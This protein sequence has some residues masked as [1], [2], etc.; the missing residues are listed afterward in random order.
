MKRVFMGLVSLIIMFVAIGAPTVQAQVEE[1]WPAGTPNTCRN[2]DDFFLNFEAGI[3]EIEIES[4][5]PSMQF[6]STGALNWKY[7]DIRT[8]KYNVYPY[9]AAVYETNGN[10][11]AWLGTLGD[12]GRI[13]F[14]GGGAT[15]STVLVSTGSGLILDAYDSNNTLI[16]SSG[17]ADP[18]TFTRTF[19]RLTVEAPVG[20][21][22]AYLLIHD[23]G[24][25]WLI[26][27]L[28]TDANKA[29]I[30][31]PGRDIGSHGDRFDL[32]FVP[33]EDYGSPADIDTWLPDFIQDI[34]D[35][36][37]QRLDAAAP[38]TGN[39]EHFNFYYTRMQG[40]AATNPH[41]LP[42]DLTQ[43]SPFADAY[44][45][46][47]TNTFGDWT[48]WG[49]PVTFGAEGAVGRSFIHE[50]GHGIFGLADEYDD[51]PDCR[52]ARFEPA[53]MPN[54]W[55]TEAGGRADAT[56]EGWNPDDIWQFTT[57][58]GGWWKLGTDSFIMTD[59][60]FFANGWGQPASRRI[61]WFLDQYPGVAAA[62]AGGP[63]PEAEKSIWL[64]IQVSAGVF[65]LLEESYIVDSPPDY[66]PGDDTFTV[67]VFSNGNG[68]L[69]EF[70]IHDP[71]IVQAERDYEGPT[72]RDSANF[73][74]IVPYFKSSGRVDLI[75]SA[76][77]NVKL[78]VDI[79]KYATVM[80][81]KTKGDIDGD[82]D[83]D[84]NDLN[85]II[86]ARNKPATGSDDPRDLDGDGKITAL[87]ARKL[88]LIC[89]R[90]RCA[91]Q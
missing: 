23:T 26:D 27:D 3:D 24:N 61:E 88:T 78:S 74:L 46:L 85:I 25:F 58:A 51:A 80:A 39:L 49:P 21:T 7:G 76:T 41:V 38:V 28:C 53:P 84:N 15:Y 2:A 87:D 40:D 42:P 68:L 63:S 13:D 35:Q 50:A 62:E 19:T 10:F 36:I 90:P 48:Q 66:L 33:D 43:I 34:Q 54:V 29:V 5:I 52:T 30:P 57:C 44:N 56:S 82:G 31:V 79:S 75:E 65:S 12:Q 17:W 11:F 69:K 71:R 47:H 86:A 20:K 67:K 18:N 55:D 91:T 14:L 81:P 37:D 72:W 59:G 45:I 1:G 16:A 60:N 32:V 77:G 6:A 22:I 64:N 73:Q 89:T 8:E 9:G 70:K 83:I 4:T